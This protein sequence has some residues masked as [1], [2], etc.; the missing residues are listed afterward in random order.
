MNYFI[1]KEN[2]LSWCSQTSILPTTNIL[3]WWSGLKTGFCFC[4]DYLHS[5]YHM[6]KQKVVTGIENIQ[7]ILLVKLGPLQIYLFDDDVWKH[8]SKE[9]VITAIIKCLREMH[10]LFCGL[11]WKCFVVHII[12]HKCTANMFV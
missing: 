4:T 8:D 5:S 2:I 7:C 12:S 6:L 3:T 1:L 9:T 10:F 11:A